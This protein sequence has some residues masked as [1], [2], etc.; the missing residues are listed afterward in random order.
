MTQETTLVRR[1]EDEVSPVVDR[2]AAISVQDSET[3]E[4]AADML[5]H[6]K[7]ARAT[8]EDIFREPKADAFKAHRS[9]CAAEK[10][11]LE[12]LDRADQ[13]LRSEVAGYRRK[14]AYERRRREEEARRKA[15]EEARRERERRF[16]EAA[17]AGDDE[18]AE[19]IL[20]TPEEVYAPEVPVEKAPPPP[21]GVSVRTTWK[22]EI[23]DFDALVAH[24]AKHGPVKFLMANERALNRFAQSTEGKMKIPGV[25]FYPQDSTVVRG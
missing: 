21:R 5:K 3:E 23:T 15:A 20:E 7:E 24:V 13:H 16:D 11:V 6:L 10:R 14:I 19:A 18:T 2:A 9:I 8:V 4:I 22:A 1:A 25:S 12:P 17:A